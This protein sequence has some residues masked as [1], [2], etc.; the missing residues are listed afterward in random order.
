MS[1]TILFSPV[2]GTD[3]ISNDN[4]RDGALL[5][6]ARVYKP[7]QIYLYMSDYAIKN[8]QSDGRYSYCL[9]KL[10]ENL[11]CNVCINMIEKPE[12]VDVYDFNYF[13]DDFRMELM[14]ITK[15]MDEEDI[16]IINT[17]SGTPAMKS[18]LVVMVTLGEVDALLIQV[19]T[20]NKSINKHDHANYDVKTLWELDPDNEP[21]F[22]NR[23]VQI[24]CPSL[25]QLKNEE[26]IKQLVNSYDYSAALEIAKMMPE[27]Y[28]A[29]Y[30]YLLEIAKDRLM[31]DFNSMDLI[32]KKNNVNDSCF[33]PVKD[34]QDRTVF[35]YAL[36]LSVKLKK[37]EYADYL[38]ALTPLN[39]SLFI[40]LI[41]KQLGINVCDFAK[42]D[43]G[44]KWSEFKLKQDDRTKKWIELWNEKYSNPFQFKYIGTDHLYYLIVEYCDNSEINSNVSLLRMVEERIR[45]TAA[46]ELSAITPERIK[47]KTK[48]TGEEIM[49]AIKHL[50]S[51]S[52]ISVSKGSWNS[53]DDMNRFI[54]D[55]IGIK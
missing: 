51:Y 53:Y 15:N 43:K 52:A 45:N 25:V 33:F 16:L 24:E 49:S 41:K 35:E 13:Y 30:L 40:S 3:P 7:D 11:G 47:S 27:K 21:D 46:H 5:H 22:E 39:M 36:N 4:Y 37:K 17:S 54:I 26:M 10:Y 9:N 19:T 14:S 6:T 29:N 31:M 48:Y 2:G 8:E 50:F 18:A 20:P 32:C 34:P 42:N 28:T 55:H 44:W 38:R 1:K 23:C 12:L